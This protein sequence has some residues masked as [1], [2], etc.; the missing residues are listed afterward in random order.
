MLVLRWQY[1]HYCEASLALGF[2]QLQ[3]AAV[4][5]A[6]VLSFN[7][8]AHHEEVEHVLN[9]ARLGK[10]GQLLGLGQ[11]LFRL[12]FTRDRFSSFLRSQCKAIHCVG[13]IQPRSAQGRPACPSQERHLAGV[14]R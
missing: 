7:C 10:P 12:S 9:D 2:T 3:A 5:D 14:W 1:Q 13:N 4:S 8:S 11:L 6:A